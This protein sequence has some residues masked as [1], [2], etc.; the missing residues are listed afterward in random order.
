M[1]R[2]SVDLVF[3]DIMMPGGMN[4]FELAR[5]VRSR[6]PELPILLTTGYSEAVSVEGAR[7]FPIVAKPYRAADV[8]QAIE[9]L[10][11]PGGPGR[12]QA[13]AGSS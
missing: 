5:A 12:T 6:R 8:A 1:E 7:E 13:A 9:R 3:S 10:F 2:E 4:G 11:E